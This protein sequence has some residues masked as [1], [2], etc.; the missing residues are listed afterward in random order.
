MTGWIYSHVEMA[1]HPWLSEEQI[2]LSKEKIHL[3]P[4]SWSCG[5]LRSQCSRVP[6]RFHVLLFWTHIF[7]GSAKLR[8]VF[9]GAV[10]WWK[11]GPGRGWCKAQRYVQTVLTEP[12]IL[13]HL[14][15]RHA[16]GFRWTFY[17]SFIFLFLKRKRLFSCEAKHIQRST[18]SA[19]TQREFL[20]SDLVPA[21]SLGMHLGTEEWGCRGV[22]FPPGGHTISQSGL[23]AAFLPAV[24][25]GFPQLCPLVPTGYCLPFTFSLFGRMWGG[26]SY[27]FYMHFSD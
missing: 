22:Y 12:L 11:L 4:I 13:H 6:S 21:V 15:P 24:S 27:G 8:A 23:Q 17:P 20:W 9:S 1:N 3:P 19:Y 18:L 14:P 5:R 26:V 25:W 10:A 7:S 16:Y 2:I